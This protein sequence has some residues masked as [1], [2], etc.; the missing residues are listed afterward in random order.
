MVFTKNYKVHDANSVAKI[1]DVVSIVE[2]RPI[3][4]SVRFVLDKV[5]EEAK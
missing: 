3:S 2:S 1:G 4:S 5:V